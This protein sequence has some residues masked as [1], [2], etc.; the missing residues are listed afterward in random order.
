MS[1]DR[2]HLD[3]NH[4]IW[5]ASGQIREPTLDDA[6]L[7]PGPTRSSTSPKWYRALARLWRAFAL[8]LPPNGWPI[9]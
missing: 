5:L 3:E 7:A 1:P 9:F 4:A 8:D 2:L 6:D